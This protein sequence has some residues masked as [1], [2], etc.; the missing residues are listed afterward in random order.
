MYHNIYFPYIYTLSPPK[1]K[2]LFTVYD[3]FY[4]CVLRVN[5]RE[6]RSEASVMMRG[7]KSPRYEEYETKVL[8]N[9][10]GSDE[11]SD[12]GVD[13]ETALDKDQNNLITV[14]EETLN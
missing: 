3:C 12:T 9:S 14:T 13:Y 10:P 5:G 8:L 4:R 7:S 2:I 1:Y 11:D 6:E